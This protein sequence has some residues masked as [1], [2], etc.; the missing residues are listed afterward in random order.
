MLAE[1]LHA[2]RVSLTVDPEV[3]LWRKTRYSKCINILGQP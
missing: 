3:W 2:V 1:G